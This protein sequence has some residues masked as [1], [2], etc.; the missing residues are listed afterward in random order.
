MKTAA[1]HLMLVAV[2]LTV[3]VGLHVSAI[4]QGPCPCVL[5]DNGAGTVTMPPNC[6]EGYLGWPTIDTGIVGGT[7]EIDATWSD[8]AGIAEIVGG[9][10]GGTQ[11]SFDALM[12][13]QM[14]GTGSLAG[15]SRTLFMPL[16]GSVVDWGARVLSDPVQTFAG[17][18]IDISGDIFG[19]P[20]FD[21][22]SFRTG[23]TFALPGT[24]PTTLTRLGPPGSDFQVDSFFDIAY[25]IEY[26]GAPGS[27]L[28]GF[29]GKVERST[30]FMTCPG[31]SPVE[32]VTWG[33]IKAL[34]R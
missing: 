7:I 14:T 19:D 16:N 1:K 8:F 10:S 6:L 15:F 25:E 3:V 26:V 17:N 20:D 18:I 9:G 27:V 29:G 22:I 31:L 13:M 4:A 12:T 23:S 24:G 28:E 33:T 34:Y 11:S 2:A 5:P 21:I 32:D 30:R